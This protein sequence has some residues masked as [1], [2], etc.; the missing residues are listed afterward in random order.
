MNA[1]IVAVFLFDAFYGNHDFF[2][3]WLRGGR[4]VMLGAYTEHLA[5]E[6][7]DFVTK[8]GA[9]AGDRLRFTPAA[10]DHNAVV[11][12]F[13]PVWLRGLPDSWRTP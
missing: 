3:A 8:N 2:E 5:Q 6:H 4:G 13:F 9:E 11:P 1:D 7:T 12:E 10:G